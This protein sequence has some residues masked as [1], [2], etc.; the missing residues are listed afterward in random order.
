MTVTTK[1]DKV[2][3]NPILAGDM[4]IDNEANKALDLTNAKNDDEAKEPNIAPKE[5]DT[6]RCFEGVES[7]SAK[8]FLFVLRTPPPFLKD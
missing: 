6:T 3:F 2:I 4:G 8:S 1:S 5:V 7:H